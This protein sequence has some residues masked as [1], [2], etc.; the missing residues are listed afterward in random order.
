[1]KVKIQCNWCG[2]TIERY[3]CKIK[4][5]NFCCKECLNAFS[6]KLKNP[7]GYANLKDFTNISSH[8]TELNAELN[9]TR[10]NPETR[11]KIRCARLDTG[12]GKS[13][14]KYYGRHEHRIVAEQI[15]GRP[16]EKYEVVHHIDGNKRNNKP[17]NLMVFKNQK[18]HAAW[19]AV[20]ADFLHKNCRK[21]KEVTPL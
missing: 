14:K 9:P 11:E 20:H 5:H 19:H 12:E 2:K 17:D 6:S 16:L 18:D 8:M 13:Y 21:S 15:I 3:P 10:M 7:V 4:K 1:M